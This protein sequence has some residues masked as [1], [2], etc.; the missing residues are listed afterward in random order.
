M[1]PAVSIDRYVGEWEMLAK[2]AEWM[3]AGR[4]DIY[5]TLVAKGHIGE[6][7]A[8]RDSLARASIAADWQAIAARVPRDAALPLAPGPWCVWALEEA[9]KGQELRLQRM[10]RDDPAFEDHI[11]LRDA[12]ACLLNYQRSPTGGPL[13]WQATERAERAEPA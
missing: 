10:R 4:A 12:I 9:L 8:I 6:Q 1:I 11:D 13:A 7:D 2:L 5:A 3:C